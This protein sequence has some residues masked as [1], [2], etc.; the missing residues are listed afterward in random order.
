MK[1]LRNVAAFERLSDG[2]LD[3]VAD[4][5]GRADFEPGA[6]LM[7]QGAIERHAII[8]LHGVVQVTV[9][10]DLG[11]VVVAT[12]STGAMVG[13]IGMLC[14]SPRTAT[15]V[16]TTPCH[17]LIISRDDVHLLA[18]RSPKFAVTIM[19]L[20]AARLEQN[21]EAIT[22]FKTLAQALRNE[23]FRVDVPAAMANRDDEVGAFARAFADMMKT[24]RDRE[25]RLQA[26]VKE[27]RVEIDQERKARQVADI[28]GTPEFKALTERAALLRARRAGPSGTSR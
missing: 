15:V 24:V 7:T 3:M 20:L 13:E 18:E 12:L 14:D 28:T 11:P 10:L 22:Y 8:L 4:T 23:T 25:A 17:G 2:D 9:T 5:C 26:E 27:L 19:Q 1:V 6:V 21:V 16:A